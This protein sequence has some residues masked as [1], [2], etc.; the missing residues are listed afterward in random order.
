MNVPVCVMVFTFNLTVIFL[1]VFF[2]RLTVAFYF[3]VG[4]LDEQDL[5]DDFVI[6]SRLVHTRKTLLSHTTLSHYT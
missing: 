5:F 4:D 2:R 6:L 1:S 3:Y